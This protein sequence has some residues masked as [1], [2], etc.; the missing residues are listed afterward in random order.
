MIEQILT[1]FGCDPVWHANTIDSALSLI[2]CH[3]PD[4][5]VLDVNLMGK[6]CYAVAVRLDDRNIPIVFS[7][8]FGA[9]GMPEFW[10]N[11]PFISKPFTIDELATA[12]EAALAKKAA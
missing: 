10:R 8:G 2:D 9:E 7:T 11:R 12:L 5:A 6:L 4:V 3:Q 1:E